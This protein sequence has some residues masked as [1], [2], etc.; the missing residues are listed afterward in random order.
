MASKNL[1]QSNASNDATKRTGRQPNTRTTHVTPRKYQNAK[2]T[3]HTTQHTTQNGAQQ[4]K[5]KRNKVKLNTTKQS[6]TQQSKTKHSK[7]K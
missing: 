7:T 5:K 3:P 1:S 4:N 2:N 6:K